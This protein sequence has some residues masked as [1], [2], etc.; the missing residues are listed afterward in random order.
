MN[1]ALDIRKIRTT[2]TGKDK[3]NIGIENSKLLTLLNRDIRLF[4]NGISSKI[5]E[6][7]YLELATLLEAGV[8]IRTALELIKNEQPK[9]RLQ[10]IFEHL[11][12]QII[13]GSTL[14]AS[15]KSSDQFTS[16]EFFSIQIG[17]ET[18]KL[19]YVLKE[20]SGFYQKK[21]KQ[22]RQI[23]GALTYPV[24]V[25]TVACAAVFF[26]MNY[27]VPMF[28]EVLKRF[29]GDLP[30]ITKLVLH[31]SLLAKHLSL[32][33]LG[34]TTASIVLV[35][36]KK[37]NPW[38]RKTSS[39]IFLK[40]PLVGQIIRK[41]YLARFSNT[42]SLLIASKIPL[43]QAIQ[44][45]K[46]MINFYPI[47]CSLIDI[48]EKI[49]TGEPLYKSM[50][51]HPIYLPKMISLIKVGEEVNQLDVFFNRIAEQYS[52]EVEHQTNQLSKFIEPFIIV[53]L[54]LIVG[55]ILIA[56]YLP[57]FKLGQNF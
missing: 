27:V 34:F 38:F 40:V 55:I 53:V 13:A 17:E 26:M 23:I 39:K 57:L 22:R 20:L 42:M 25:L 10:Q 44:L 12:A 41:I 19:I 47:E 50:Q 45:V 1:N 51:H 52:N 31:L 8:D 48:E 16:Y 4:D 9:K 43:L 33:F 54:G 2:P 15:L 18:G 37:K 7:F 29:G 5:K 56:M 24:L 49:L 14:S 21:V 11:C 46:Q 28:A 32:F 35:I 36:T 3:N 30:F 6:L